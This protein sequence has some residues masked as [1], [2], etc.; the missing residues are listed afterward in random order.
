M[1]NAVDLAKA[2]VRVKESKE[3]NES[4]VNAQNDCVELLWMMAKTTDRKKSK[5]K[6]MEEMMMT[7]NVFVKQLEIGGWKMRVVSW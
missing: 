7:M 3:S 2:I 5:M 1:V 6:K 4:T